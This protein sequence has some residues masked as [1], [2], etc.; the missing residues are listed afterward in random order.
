MMLRTETVKALSQ[1]LGLTQNQLAYRIGI[2]RGAFS[3][4]INGKTG[5]GR[6]TLAGLLRLFPGQSVSSLTVERLVKP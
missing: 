1:A 5:V 2:S 6:K 4:A 3:R